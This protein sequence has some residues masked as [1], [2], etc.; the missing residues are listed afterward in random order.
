MTKETNIVEESQ[1]E[2]GSKASNF[3]NW[4]NPFSSGMGMYAWLFQ[5][6]T[7][8]CLLIY[9]FIHMGIVSLM[10]LDPFL[11]LDQAG[12]L[13]NTV[14]HSMNQTLI[15]TGNELLNHMV[16]LGFFIDAGVM[17]FGI[18]HGANG[19][20][21]I[22]FDF[23]IGIRRQK[24]I[25]WIFLVLGVIAWLLGLLLIAYLP[26]IVTGGFIGGP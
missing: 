24:M 21:V 23:G 13:Y 15:E 4:F 8:L 3:I 20:R 14:I 19:I 11:G 10:L 18:Y 22:L 9:V 25:F 6:I 2:T 1:V 7:G 12:L 16:S 5:R 26:G 17:A